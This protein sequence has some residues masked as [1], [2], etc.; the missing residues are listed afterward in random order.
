MD[1]I[2]GSL[3]INCAF[4]GILRIVVGGL[5]GIIDYNA[6]CV[7][8]KSMHFAS[9]MIVVVSFGMIA[10]I[11]T[12]YDVDLLPSLYRRIIQILTLSA[13]SITGSLFLQNMLVSAELYP[14]VIRNL[15]NA[16][17]ST[18]ARIGAVVGPALFNLTYPL[19]YMALFVI[20]LLDAL[21]FQIFLPET[22]SKPLPENMPSEDEAISG[23]CRNRKQ[24]HRSTDKV[25]ASIKRND[26]DETSQRSNSFI[27][28]KFK[29]LQPISD[30]SDNTT[31]IPLPI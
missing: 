29:K 23:C 28:Y 21:A 6:K 19:P 11:Y 22:K 15:A 16:H 7:G 30:I 26:T 9:V 2:S 24:H 1:K 14:T 27:V 10:A 17:S 5:V 25:D 13:F 20:A 31:T 18:W 4:G 8:R 3:Y 12:V